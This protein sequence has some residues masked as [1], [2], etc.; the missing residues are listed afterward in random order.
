[1]NFSLYVSNLS[2]Y[3]LELLSVL[4]LDPMCILD[5]ELPFVV[6]SNFFA[7]RVCTALIFDSSTAF[8]Y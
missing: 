2:L 4:E 1:M 7:V 8:L 5:C 6:G 3:I